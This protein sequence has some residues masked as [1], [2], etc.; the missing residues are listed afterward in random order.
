MTEQAEAGDKR[1]LDRVR[2]ILAAQ[3]ILG[4]GLADIPCQIKDL[5]ETGARIFL[6]E[7]ALLPERFE[8]RIPKKGLAQR[9]EVRWR[10]GGLVGV[11][12]VRERRAVER[13]DPAARIKQ[14]EA[15]NAELR[16][17]VADMAERLYNYGDGERSVI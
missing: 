15:E 13:L 9:V 5:S 7:K 16:R 4:K 10:N 14:L 17:R 6:D 12:F 8:L 3:A 1:R 11:E 2:T